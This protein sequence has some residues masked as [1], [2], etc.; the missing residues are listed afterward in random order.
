ML[1]KV[2]MCYVRIGANLD[3]SA[4]LG[5]IFFGKKCKLKRRT[6]GGWD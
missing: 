2:N 4:I 6:Y 5:Y 3:Y 1:K